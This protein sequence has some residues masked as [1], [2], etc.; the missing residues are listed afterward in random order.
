MKVLRCL[1]VLSVILFA[2]SCAK[3]NQKI[4]LK[5]ITLTKLY[6]IEGY[7]DSRDSTRNFM[8]DYGS[9]IA[10]EN[11]DLIIRDK[12]SGSIKVFDK[13][14]KFVS[15]I[16]KKGVGPEEIQYFNS[17]L[18]DKD[19]IIIFDNRNHIKKF[20]KN[21]EF[22]SAKTLKQ[23]GLRLFE[24]M[25]P[26]NDSTMIGISSF[27]RKVKNGN[28]IDIELIFSDRSFNILKILEI[29]QNEK[30]DLDKVFFDE[31]VFTFNKENIFV[32]KRSKSEYK[33]KVYSLSGDYLRTLNLNYARTK[34]DQHEKDMISKLDYLTPEESKIIYDFKPAM[35]GLKTDKYG[36]IWVIKSKGSFG[37]DIDFDILS[38]GNLVTNLT[39]KNDDPAGNSEKDFIVKEYFY[40][41]D[42][43]NN[44][45]EVYDYKIE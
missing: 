30:T 15:L 43:D 29:N 7:A 41:I 1:I 36:N 24:N 32:S 20:H 12:K 4:P 34:Y 31:P 10:D 33:I 18:V 21:G 37:S 42:Y 23:P 44:L 8:L 39:I 6:T 16:S 13:S 2:L 27:Y 28:E 17:F 45:I 35:Y 25:T 26:F 19:T 9:V 11:G 38:E 5:K 40:I 3:D 22:I 14:G